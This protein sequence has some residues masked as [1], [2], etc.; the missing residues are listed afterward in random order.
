M[1][2]FSL[3]WIS[4][5]LPERLQGV[6]FFFEKLLLVYNITKEF[7]YHP[8][9]KYFS[10]SPIKVLE[11][12][13]P[14]INQQLQHWR[15]CSEVFPVESAKVLP[16]NPV[17]VLLPNRNFG[18][19]WSLTNTYIK[20][21]NALKFGTSTFQTLEFHPFEANVSFLFPLKLSEI[22]KFPGV[23]WRA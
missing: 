11:T 16:K 17:S 22:H 1:E 8:V 12:I 5:L 2:T 4:C 9:L 10:K 3:A 14:T 18:R 6:D 20:F 21:A 23:G 13:K 15:W 19:M 7:A